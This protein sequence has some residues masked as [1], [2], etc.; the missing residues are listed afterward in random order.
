MAITAQDV[1]KLRKMTSAGMMDC[2]NALTEAN[3]DFQKAVEIIREKGKL[4][5]AKRADRETT[6]GAVL[7]RINGG[8]AIIVCLGCET[9]FVSATPDFKALAAEIADAAIASFPADL[10]ALK[11]CKCTNGHTVEEE[12]SAQTGKT[13]EKHI[14]AYYAALEAPYVAQYVHFNGKLGSIV[15]FNKEVPE[16]LGR[17][18]AQQV[19]AMNPV[20]VSEADCPQEVIERERVVAIQKTKDEQVQ[21]AVDA[22]LKKVGINPAHVDSEDHIESNTA[23]GWITPEQAAQA[24]EIIAKVGAEKAANLPEQMVQNIANGRVQKFLKE[25]TLENQDFVQS[26]EKVSVAGYIKTVDPEAKVL[27]FRRY[28]LND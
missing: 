19:T 6:E 5:A 9:D 23:K 12:I 3:G 28:S 10:E 7:V 2:K 18:V 1:M 25:N 21:K 16:D 26:D 15:A 4:V 13:G 24:R 11:A 14:L 8:K 17:A 20:S 27:S 22:A